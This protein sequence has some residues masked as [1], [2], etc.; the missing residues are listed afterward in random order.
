MH[1]PHCPCKKSIA[2]AMATAGLAW[3]ITGKTADIS[4]IAKGRTGRMKGRENRPDMGF[5]RPC[6]GV[7]MGN[8]EV[9]GKAIYNTM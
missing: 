1:K 2:P 7:A 5:S 3:R 9:T 6:H 8:L 4:H